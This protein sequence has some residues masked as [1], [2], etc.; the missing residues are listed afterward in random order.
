[1]A[2]WLT[3]TTG[4]KVE[5]AGNGMT[6]QRGKVIL[7]PDGHHIRVQSRDRLEVID[8]PP[9][10]AHRPSGTLLFRSVA[11]VFTDRVLA[12]ILTG[13]GKDGVEGLHTVRTCRGT[14]LAQAPETC[15]VPGMPSAAIHENLADLVLSPEQIAEEI[16][17]RATPRSRTGT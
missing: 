16:I 9:I 8:D 4:T 10:G 12:V 7:A 11:Q 6:L 5:V 15:V 17:A 2:E 1:L 3:E 13:M 14:V